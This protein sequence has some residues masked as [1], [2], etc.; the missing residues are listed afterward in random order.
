MTNYKFLDAAA[1][2]GLTVLSVK[3]TKEKY[4]DSITFSMSNGKSYKM[5]HKQDCCEG[6]NITSIVGDLE[7]LIGSPIIVAREETDS[8][9][10]PADEQGPEYMDDSHTWT[11]YW[12]ETETAKVRIR[13]LGTSNGYYSESVEIEEVYN[14]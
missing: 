5:F 3:R 2:K 7:S 10:S 12:F 13:W 11:T 9:G 4:D 8:E 14:A 1:M 6:V